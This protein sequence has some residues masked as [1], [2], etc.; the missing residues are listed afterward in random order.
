MKKR[1][2][3][4]GM[5]LLLMMPLCVGCQVTSTNSEGIVTWFEGPL[6]D[7]F[8]DSRKNVS[9]LENGHID[10]MKNET[11]SIQIG[12]HAKEQ[13]LTNLKV[14]VKEFKGKNA[15]NIQVMPVRLVYTS[16]ASRGYLDGVATY[17]RGVSPGEYPEIHD[18]VDN[19]VGHVKGLSYIVPQGESAAVAVE[20]TTDATTEP[21]EYETTVYF[22]GDQG[23]VRV[24]ITVKVWDITLP[25]PKDSSFSYTN[26]FNSCSATAVGSFA[27]F[28]D[29]YG[30]K[31]FDDTFF[32]VLANY[33]EVM[34]KERQNIMMIP[35][36]HLLA[37]DMTFGT[38]GTYQFTFGT[39]DRFVETCLENG[40]IKALEG[41][42]FYGKDYY[43]NKDPKQGSMVTTILE[44][45][46]NGKAKS[47]IVLAET[48]E[49]DRHFDQLIPALYAH[50]KEKGWETMWLQHV[51][52]EPLSQIQYDQINNMYER[53]LDEM[54]GVRT[55]DA[56]SGQLEKFGERNCLSIYCP[57]LDSYEAARDSYNQINT[58]KDNGRDSWMYTCV[59]PQDG[60]TMTRIADYPLISARV[61]G[62]YSW[63]Q[64]LK[65]YLHWGWNLWD[66]S[67]NSPNDPAN[68]MYCT[69]AVA[70]GFLVYPNWED[71]SVFEGPRATSVRDGW[72]DYE[73]L[74][75]A[76]AKN[77]AAT[78]ELV[79]GTVRTGKNFIRSNKQLAETRVALLQLAA[80]E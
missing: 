62:W 21:G 78:T 65:G 66:K 69:D 57:Q 63:Q 52:D 47:K 40:S 16:K 6:T 24:P 35:T 45:D 70:D 59:N 33:A 37:S 25:E 10:V 5:V 55:L 29:I 75:L 17:A 15:P 58:T 53:I 20:V 76:A 4:I 32:Q 14:T 79:N 46:E 18:T 36:L 34:K 80:G 39:F 71:L 48:P 11:E 74:A 27:N 42:F 51:C 67:I 3:A 7:I 43:I 73:L 49:A 28:M 19:T 12:V 8:R 38:D 54:P 2:L 1:L 50:L 13:D 26:W 72:E 77:E 60:N 30:S 41:S 61:I 68:D 23:K 64:G 56:G 31:G 9:S 22:E 44:P